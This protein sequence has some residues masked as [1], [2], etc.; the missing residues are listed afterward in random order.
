MHVNN[1][2]TMYIQM[3]WIKDPPSN[4]CTYY[5]SWFMRMM[6]MLTFIKTTRRSFQ[7]EWIENRALHFASCV[8]FF[9]FMS[10]RCS[11]ILGFLFAVHFLVLSMILL[12]I[13][14]KDIRGPMNKMS[15]A[16]EQ[17]TGSWGEH[18]VHFVALTSKMLFFRFFLLFF[19]LLHIIII[20]FC[21]CKFV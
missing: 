9:L 11:M 15:Q 17:W 6:I 19:L 12:F 2:C 3:N 21:Y 20:V 10:C 7:G 16:N 14:W 4:H 1:G 8:Q 5:I 13:I 18:C